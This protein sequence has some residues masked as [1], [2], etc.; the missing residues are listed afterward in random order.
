MGWEIDH[1]F[2]LFFRTNFWPIFSPF[3]NLI[4]DCFLNVRKRYCQEKSQQYLNTVLGTCIFN[5]LLL[6]DSA[7]VDWILYNTL[8]VALQCVVFT[9]TISDCIWFNWCHLYTYDYMLN[10][11][12]DVVWYLLLFHGKVTSWFDDW[13]APW[14]DMSTCIYTWKS[15]LIRFK[16]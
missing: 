16:T 7:V 10:D 1:I 6:W 9:I 4:L 14:F 5:F 13:T 12:I 2:L 15:E 3:L 11:D 8:N